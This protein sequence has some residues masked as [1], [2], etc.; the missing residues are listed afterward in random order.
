[1]RAFLLFIFFISSATIT[2][3]QVPV[4]QNDTNTY[5]VTK[6]NGSEYIGKILNDDGREVLIQTETLGKI[7]IPKA[8]I[9][10]IVLLEDKNSVIRGEYYG[11]GP[12]TTRHA[13]T[14][15]ALPIKKGE[16]YALI[17]L[18]G[19][20][21]H[22]AITNH[23]NI[24]IMSTWLASPLVFAAKYTLPTRNEKL[25]FSLGT[26]LGTSG[27]FNNFQGFG[28][29]H[30]ANV[31][32]GDRKN[33]ITFSAGYSYASNF[34][35]QEL[36]KPASYYSTDGYSYSYAFGNYSAD[37]IRGPI[38][39]I[40]GMAKVGA[41]ASFIFDSMLGNFSNSSSSNSFVYTTITD[42]TPPDYNNGLYQNTVSIVKTKSTNVYALFIMPGMRFQ[43]KENRAFQVSLAGVAL[44]DNGD[45][46]SAPIPM[47]SWFYKF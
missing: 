9:K 33:N 44:F 30:F 31:T 19:P 23:L 10:S 4:N 16:N 2:F 35:G 27:Y 17:N 1:M 24:G 41:K 42:A 15:N 26:L 22:F 18:Y 46:Y 39:S 8:D 32:Y 3:S 38:F 37:M 45:N 20:E 36:I 5:I 47:C 21:V 14:T 43:T 34:R 40:A 28:G 25:N 12:F 13:F 29:L 11:S 6:S 7:Y